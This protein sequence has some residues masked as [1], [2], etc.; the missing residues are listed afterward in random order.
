M[1]PSEKV[2]LDKKIASILSEKTGVVLNLENVQSKLKLLSQ[3]LEDYKG[4]VS[5]YIESK[6]KVISIQ[7]N[8]KTSNV[9]SSYGLP[10][11]FSNSAGNYDI[12]EL[13]KAS[14]ANQ[15]A[16]DIL[17][18]VEA[19][20]ENAYRQI[21]DGVNSVLHSLRQVSQANDRIEQSFFE[22]MDNLDN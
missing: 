5:Q 14:E 19:A 11:V 10:G 17:N 7:S 9:G 22:V 20:K 1:S 13:H 18:T 21:V 3:I 6:A 8:F 12:D 15:K 2:L 4:T 16:T